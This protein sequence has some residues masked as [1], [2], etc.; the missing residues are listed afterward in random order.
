MFLCLKTNLK[1]FQE[2]NSFLM[3]IFDIL[4]KKKKK[5]V[6]LLAACTGQQV[7]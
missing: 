6:F 5:N 7:R 1:L 3:S 2:I 4:A